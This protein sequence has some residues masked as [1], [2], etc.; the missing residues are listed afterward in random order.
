MCS[1]HMQGWSLCDLLICPAIYMYFSVIDPGFIS[2]QMCSCVNRTL[3]S[4]ENHPKLCLHNIIR[5]NSLFGATL[6]FSSTILSTIHHFPYSV[7]L[8]VAGFFL[9]PFS[10]GGLICRGILSTLADHNVQSFISLSSPQAGQ[11][12]GG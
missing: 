3:H 1:D 7:L 6:T 11:Y 2:V 8:M 4:T 9:L 10:K 5:V 12:G